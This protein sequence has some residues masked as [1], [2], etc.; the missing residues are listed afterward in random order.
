MQNSRRHRRR[1]R[2]RRCPHA[3]SS[4]SRRLPTHQSRRPRP[5]RSTRPRLLDRAR[6]HRRITRAACPCRPRTVAAASTFSSRTS[7][8]RAT[9]CPLSLVL[10]PPRRRRL[11][12]HS[13]Q[14]TAPIR[15]RRVSFRNSTHTSSSN[16]A[17][18]SALSLSTRQRLT[19]NH[20]LCAKCARSFAR[21]QL[22]RDDEPRRPCPR[23]GA[24]LARLGPTK[25]GAALLCRLDRDGQSRATKGVQRLRPALQQADRPG[26][27][28]WVV[29]RRGRS[30]PAAPD[31]RQAAD[32]LFVV[33]QGRLCHTHGPG[34]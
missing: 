31:A 14:T 10:R 7:S 30:G 3:P 8:Q 32:R 13:S 34:T 25:V 21:A 11:P 29:D 9:R 22:L 1:T 2:R 6:E 18:P 33:A 20:S 16:R 17:Q 4:R 23:P 5:S 27:R 24:A 26:G 19:S 28:V 12:D 15:F